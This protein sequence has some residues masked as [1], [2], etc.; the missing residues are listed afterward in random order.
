[1][2]TVPPPTSV[3]TPIPRT[4]YQ[5]D[6]SISHTGLVLVS[7]LVFDLDLVLVLVLGLV[8]GMP[9][10]GPVSVIPLWVWGWVDG[11]FRGGYSGICRRSPLFEREPQRKNFFLPGLVLGVG[12]GTREKETRTRSH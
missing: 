9:L 11:N 3:L 2:T 12:A 4:Y 6:P 7:V 10:S 5:P 1:M 8:F